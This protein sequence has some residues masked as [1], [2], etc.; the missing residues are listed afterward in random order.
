MRGDRGHG[1]WRFH[2]VYHQPPPPD[3]DDRLR[4]LMNAVRTAQVREYVD[5]LLEDVEEI[6]AGE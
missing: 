4:E 3:F 2:L 6:G 1:A 5:K